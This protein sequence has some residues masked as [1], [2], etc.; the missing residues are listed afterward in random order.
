MAAPHVAGIAALILSVNPCLTLQQ[1]TNIIENTC[2]K[3]GGYNYATIVGRFNGLWNNEMGYGLVDAYAAVLM[4]QQQLNPT[5]PDLY[6][7]DSNTDFGVEPSNAVIAWNSPDIWVRNQQDIVQT[8][9]APLYHPTNP[10]YIYVKVRNRGCNLS[11][12][13]EVLKIY[14]NLPNNPLTPTTSSYRVSNPLFASQDTSSSSIIA[15]S[16]TFQ[17]IGSVTIPVLNSGQFAILS[18]PWNVPNPAGLLNCTSFNF[19]TFIYAKIVST[20]DLITVPETA[21][22]LLNIVNN[23]NIAGKSSV[24]LHHKI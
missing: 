2:Q 6:I 7:A 1:V 16:F 23:N 8:H 3:V 24:V 9:Q 20:T 17:L 12:G 14:A 22:N 4:A 18:I 21:N 10:N 15:N 11:T 13:N 5:N 19:D